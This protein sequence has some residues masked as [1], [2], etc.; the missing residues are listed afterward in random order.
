MRQAFSRPCRAATPA[1]LA[2][3]ALLGLPPVADAAPAGPAAHAAA[4]AA[5]PASCVECANWN[6]TQSPFRIYGNTYYVGGH[7]LTSLLI[8]G[9]EGHILIDG[10]LAESAPKIAASIRARDFKVED[11]K[12][13]LNSH[14]HYDHA[15][16]LAPLQ[17]L[18]GGASG[19]E[20]PRGGR[21]QH[22]TRR[23]R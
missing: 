4:D 13:L 16:G 2:V 1:A 8:T 5:P 9:D 20:R 11:V 12:L 19:R 15:G 23:H 3:C 22:R 7:G 14:V 21:A 18:W 6:S 17:R 10:A